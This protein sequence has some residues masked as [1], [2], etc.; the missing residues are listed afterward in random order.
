[1]QDT[2]IHYTLQ[3]KKEFQIDASPDQF[4]IALAGNPNVGKSTIFNALTG[5]RQHTGNWPGK[6]VDNAQGT[7]T[8]ESQEFLLVDLPGTYSLSAHSSEEEITRD[9]ISHGNPDVTLI[10]VDAS[11][12]ERNLN[13]ALQILEITPNVVLCV[14][15]LDEAR[16]KNI[17]V[18]LDELS[19]ELAIPVI[20]TTARTG[21]GLNQLKEAIFSISKNK[22]PDYPPAQT[23]TTTDVEDKITQIYAKAEMICRKVVTKPVEQKKNW[24]YRL[25]D[26]LTSRLFGYPIMFFML[27][28]VFW[29]TIEGANYPSELLSSILFSFEDTLT[30]LFMA[31]NA[32]VWLH[33]VLILGMYRSLAWVVSVMLPPMAIFFPLFTLLEDL[34]YLPRVAFNLDSAFR[35]CHASGKQ[36]LTM[37]ISIFCMQ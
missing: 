23:E 12:L 2:R 20:G 22:K 8:H 30:D 5:L 9:F 26:I 31:M 19:K 6:T 33:G 3:R 37:C 24:E 14:N 15:L 36:V 13:L 4:V 16:R 21:R 32:P 28:G 25:D 17:T 7:F 11:C 18:N 1:M 35:K 29:L 27:C 34:G 10:V